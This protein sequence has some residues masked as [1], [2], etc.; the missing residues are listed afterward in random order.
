MDQGYYF[1]SLV[2]DHNA[3]ANVHIA[4]PHKH[5]GGRDD[6]QL[7]WDSN[8]IYTQFNSSP[9]DIGLQNYATLHN[10]YSVFPR[11]PE[12]MDTF[13]YRGAL[14]VPITGNPL[15]SIAPYAFPSAPQHQFP[16]RF[17]MQIATAITTI[18]VSSNSNISTTSVLTRICV[19]TPIVTTTTTS[20][21]AR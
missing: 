1:T 21:R 19:R 4:V 9:N 13:S 10:G 16:D 17:P 2:G 15:S 6:I 20:L 18:P 5:D 12:Y 7:L 3:V 14:G 8:Y 11:I